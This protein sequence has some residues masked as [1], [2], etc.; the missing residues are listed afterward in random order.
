MSHSDSDDNDYLVQS[1][2]KFGDDLVTESE[3]KNQSRKGQQ[4]HENH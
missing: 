3:K 2:D 4:H 1:V